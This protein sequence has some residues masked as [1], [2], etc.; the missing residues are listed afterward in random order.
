MFLYLHRVFRL[1]KLYRVAA[2]I[3]RLSKAV[4][5]YNPVYHDIRN[6][7]IRLKMT[8]VYINMYTARKALSGTRSLRD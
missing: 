3:F 5:K 8:A 4:E 6:R 7:M 1:S 2:Y